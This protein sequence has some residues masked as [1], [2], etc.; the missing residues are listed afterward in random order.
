[1]HK[2]RNGFFD[3]TGGE[4]EQKEKADETSESGKATVGDWLTVQGIQNHYKTLYEHVY[5][6]DWL[7]ERS[8]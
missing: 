2:L 1:M 4:E 7:V 3:S 8:L 5:D 6:L